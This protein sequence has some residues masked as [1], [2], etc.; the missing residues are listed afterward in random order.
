M[1]D[2]YSQF[3]GPSKEQAIKEFH[4]PEWLKPFI[5]EYIETEYTKYGLGSQ[6]GWN[7]SVKPSIIKKINHKIQ[8]RE[9][10]RL[11]LR[12][13][14]YHFQVYGVFLKLYKDVYY[15][16]NGDYMKHI[17]SYYKNIFK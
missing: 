10:A 5:I 8:L 4:Y 9:K 12:K 16:P 7:V 15:K 6:T 17:Q 2:Y 13:L 11:L 3:P 1:N 14:F